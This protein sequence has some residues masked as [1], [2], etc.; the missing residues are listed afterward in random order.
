MLSWLEP[1]SGLLVLAGGWQLASIIANNPTLVPPLQTIWAALVDLAHTDLTSDII[2]SLIHLAGGF[3]TGAALGLLLAL[4]CARFQL[5]AVVIDPIAEFLRPI[6]AIAWIPIAILLFGVGQGVPMFLIFYASLF[7]IFV[8]ALDG[9]RRVDPTLIR[10]AEMLGASR[11]LVVTHIV[12]PAALPA[13]FAGARLSLGVGWVAMVAG[14]LVGAD[15]GLGYRIEYFQEFFSMEGVMAAIVVVGIVGYV[16]DALLRLLQASL[17]R[18]SPV[19]GG[20]R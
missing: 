10:A 16:L 4:F 17:L 3:G 18:W 12:L 2:A 11:R 14:E 15:T 19:N 7:P 9:I 8:N 13:V 20:S 6:S 5:V 1:M